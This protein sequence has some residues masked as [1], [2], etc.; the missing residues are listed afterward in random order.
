LSHKQPRNGVL[1]LP[2][3]LIDVNMG[4][5]GFLYNALIDPMLG[6]TVV[7]AWVLHYAKSVC[8]VTDT[9]ALDRVRFDPSWND[10][11]M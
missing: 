7:G 2:S 4:G 9:R 3:Y 5:L 11:A 1:F 6:T 8:A 10:S